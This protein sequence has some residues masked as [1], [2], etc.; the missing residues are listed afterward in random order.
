VVFV[1]NAFVGKL[2][3][4]LLRAS[5]INFIISINPVTNLVIPAKQAVACASWNPSLKA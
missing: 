4:S 3:D 5:R 2:I 1:V